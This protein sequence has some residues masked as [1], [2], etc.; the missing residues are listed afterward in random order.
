MQAIAAGRAPRPKHGYG[1]HRLLGR[2]SLLPRP[3][4]IGLAGP[5]ARPA[6]TLVTLA[7]IAFG[8][9]AVIFGFGLGASLNQI[10]ADLSRSRPG[11]GGRPQAD[12]KV[13]YWRTVNAGTKLK[14]WNTKPDPA[15]SQLRQLRLAQADRL[16]PPRC[17]SPES[18][19]PSRAAELGLTGPDALA[20]VSQQ[21][22]NL[23]HEPE[24]AD[25]QPDR[26]ATGNPSTSGSGTLASGL[27]PGVQRGRD[28]VAISSVNHRF[29][30]LPGKAAVG[31]RGSCD[32]DCRIGSGH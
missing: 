24:L 20:A 6:R 18:G 28:S 23:N 10:Q 12:G 27:T 19:R 15:A 1:A 8:G 30:P 3:M 26:E 2:A 25:G 13:T 32:R 5:F 4:T 21:P 7:A 22:S 11:R 31:I 29:H 9:T 14:D 17:T 16:V